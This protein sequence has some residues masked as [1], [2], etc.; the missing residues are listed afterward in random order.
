MKQVKVPRWIRNII[1]IV[2][3]LLTY[4]F[5]PDYVVYFATFIIISEINYKFD[6]LENE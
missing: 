5:L 6:R 4:I 2:T 1:Y 3:L